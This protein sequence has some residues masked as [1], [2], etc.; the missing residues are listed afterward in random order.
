MEGNMKAFSFDSVLLD[1]IKT[2]SLVAKSSCDPLPQFVK[3][4]KMLKNKALKE[5][6]TFYRNI[7]ES[8]DTVTA[9]EAYDQFFATMVKL[10]TYYSIRYNEVLEDSI[11]NI[12]QSDDSKL[13]KV[14]NEYLKDFNNNDTIIEK[15]IT[16][17]RFDPKVPLSKNI[18][19]DILNFF[20]GNYYE[21]SKN[22]ARKLLEITANN[23]RKIINDIKASIINVDPDSIE[24][25]DISK[26]SFVFISGNDFISFHKNN[27]ANCI[28]TVQNINDLLED[29]MADA[30][31]INKDYRLLLNRVVQYRNST[32]I[33][34][35]TDEYTRKIERIIVNIISE[36]WSYHLSVYMFKMK[37]I[38]DN[39]TQSK[40]VLY[41]ILPQICGLDDYDDSDLDELKNKSGK[42]LK[43]QSMK[44][45]RL[46]DEEI[47]MNSI[48][49]MKHNELIMDCCI[50]EAMIL[51]E[52]VDVNN[53]L[54]ALHEGTW[55]KIKEIYNKIKNFITGLFDKVSNWFDK[56]YK[57]NKDYIEKYKNQIDKP[58]AGFTTVNIPN[59]KEGLARIQNPTTIN[60][61][62]IVNKSVNVSD[63]LDVDK[64]IDDFRKGIINTYNPNDDWKE[65]CNDYFK[66]G[67]DSEKDV[68]ANEIVVR[69]LA[70]DVLNIPK[71]IDGI[72]KDK[73]TSDQIF[74]SLESAIAKTANQ[75]QA[76]DNNTDQSTTNTSSN[77]T[78]NTSSNNTSANTNTNTNNVSAQNA[79]T[80]LYGDVFS[81]LEFNGQGAPG[82]NNTNTSN[83]TKAGNA[84]I[85][86]VKNSNVSS[87]NI[88]KSQKIINQVA[89]TYST[90]LQCKYQMAEKIMS[91][92]MKI[93]KV[94]VSAYIN[95]SGKS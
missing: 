95:N 23:Q 93:I 59:Y 10:N 92:Y 32:K 58:T 42:F 7:L 83:I 90:Y 13:I 60:F 2:P 72:K 87:K 57:S 91:D 30:K 67:K 14:V 75:Q 88:V 94:H 17:Y 49:D 12:D 50:K 77:N 28:E 29:T 47:L 70:N 56:F 62:D 27:I 3:L 63:D 21:L 74:K 44:F 81:E 24:A 18:L 45:N 33:N 65:I 61:Q 51:A 53:R 38:I 11:N 26:V 84:A 5:N 73:S 15:E 82:A 85:D 19:I 54:S 80:Y 55:D 25:K 89:S 16:N 48:V 8:A 31:N 22:E 46:T 78:N 69:G 79:A 1:K 4:T 76:A 43:E 41:S 66:G 35:D 37:C 86:N 6:Q 40:E 71:I 20:G 36:I 52:G 64:V 9:K 34:I 39:Y 68:S